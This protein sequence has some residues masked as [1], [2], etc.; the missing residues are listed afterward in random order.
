MNDIDPAF[1]TASAQ[2]A[3]SRTT[4]PTTSSSTARPTRPPTTSRSTPGDHVLLRA[5]NLG[6]RGSRARV[7]QLRMMSSATTAIKSPLDHRSSVESKL[8]TPGQVADITTLVD[9]SATVGHQFAMLDLDRHLNNS[10]EA[11]GRRHADVHRRRRRARAG[12]HRRRQGHRAD[13]RPPTTARQNITVNYTFSGGTT[14]AAGSSTP[15]AARAPRSPAADGSMTLSIPSGADH[16]RAHGRPRDLDPALERLRSRR[17]VRRR[18]H[19]RA[20]GPTVF[21]LTT[22]PQFANLSFNKVDPN[23]PGSTDVLLTGSALAVAA[24]LHDRRR[25]GVPHPS[26]ADGLVPFADCVSWSRRR[27]WRRRTSRR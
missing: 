11:R 22:D 17:A 16:V 8:L 3:T 13:A 18:V 27:R 26:G 24:R 12:Q 21:A 25:G 9:P 20:Q 2:R 15:S 10:A 19:P 6:I 14:S 7:G 4:T 23:P 1:N 5:A